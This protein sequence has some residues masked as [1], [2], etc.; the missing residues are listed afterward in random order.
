MNSNEA[1]DSEI[2]KEEVS[3]I[4]NGKVCA[5]KLRIARIS[6]AKDVNVQE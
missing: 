3:R 6:F 1:K 4:R 5:F 2:A